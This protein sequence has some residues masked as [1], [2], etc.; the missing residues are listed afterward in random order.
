MVHTTAGEK[1]RGYTEVH[2]EPT[3]DDPTARFYKA[4]MHKEKSTATGR[5]PIYGTYNNRNVSEKFIINTYYIKDFDEWTRSHYTDTFK[6][7]QKSKRF[8]HEKAQIRKVHLTDFRTEMGLLFGLGSATVFLMILATIGEWTRDL[9]F[10]TNTKS[11]IPK[12][13]KMSGSQR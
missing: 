8:Q 9:P 12:E 4:R 6:E 7:E 10:D 5:T 11:E 13:Q 2:K 3:E 1:Y